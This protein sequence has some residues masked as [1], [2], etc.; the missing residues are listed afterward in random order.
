MNDNYVPIACH[1]YDELE[2]LAVKRV[3]SKIVY[4]EDYIQKEIED[5][6]VDFK[7]LN[8]EEFMLLQSGLQIRL[9]KIISVNDKEP[10]L[11]C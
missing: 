10:S 4:S 1:F 7:T 8:K 11:Y 5:F 9:D 2:A 3:K 6:I